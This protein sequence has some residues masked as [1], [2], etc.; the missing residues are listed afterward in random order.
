MNAELTETPTKDGLIHQGMLAEGNGST[1]ILWIHALGNAFYHG[2]AR[3]EAFIACCREKELAYAAFNNRGHDLL[4]SSKIMENG[5]LTGKRRA[6]GS[7]VEHFDECVADIDAAI[8]FL[9]SKGYKKIVLA[10]YSSGA[11]KACYYEAKTKDPR[12]SGVVLISPLNDRLGM[13]QVPGFGEML[14]NM[15]AQRER[16]NG[17]ALD[18]MAVPFPMTPNRFLSLCETGSAEDVFDYD[19]PEGLTQFSSI[20]TPVL[21]I[22]AG[23]DEH[24]DRPAEEIRNAFDRKAGSERY[25]S[26]IVE[27]ADH[28]FT[29]KEQDLARLTTDWIG[30]K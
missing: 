4:T 10:G 16:G 20:T 30:E 14:S 13:Q 27:G 18:S 1:A 29:G 8:G 24:A 12:V 19:N 3:H 5:K 22:L 15:K 21:V 26:V 6:I 25:R 28:G 2:I 11:N 7:S 9:I 17:D 23:A